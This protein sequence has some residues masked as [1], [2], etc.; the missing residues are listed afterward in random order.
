MTTVVLVFHIILAIAMVGII[1]LQKNEGGGLG[2]GSG[3]M[4]G[5][6]SS[7]GTANLLTRTTAILAGL[8][9]LT[10]LLLAIL[11]KGAHKAQSILDHPDATK[12]AIEVPVEPAPPVVASESKAQPKSAE[13]SVASKNTST[14]K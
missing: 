11:F 5:L 13:G 4:G 2:M 7:R 10:T 8:F 12:P 14:K 3:T 1:L 9:F 6:M